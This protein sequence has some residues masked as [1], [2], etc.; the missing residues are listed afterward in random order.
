MTTCL[1]PHYFPAQALRVGSSVDMRPNVYKEYVIEEA[2]CPKGEFHS[3]YSIKRYWKGH[4][5]W[6]SEGMRPCLASLFKP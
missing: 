5:S 3:T 4:V 2:G 1:I 6:L